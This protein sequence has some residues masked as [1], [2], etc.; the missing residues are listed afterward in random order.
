[1]GVASTG[2][3]AGRGTG[4]GGSASLRFDIERSSLRDFAPRSSGSTLAEAATALPLLSVVIPVYNERH[5]LGQVLAAVARALPGVR[6]NIVVGDD[7]ST[8]GPREWL[9]ANF[10]V[11]VRTGSEISVDGAGRL[12]VSAPCNQAPVSIEPLYHQQNRGK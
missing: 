11:G 9:K 6:K 8:A 5:T 2:L 4:S 12:D 3:G 7:C 1:M 10:P